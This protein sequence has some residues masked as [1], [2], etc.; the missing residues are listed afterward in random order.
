MLKML[1]SLACAGVVSLPATADIVPA[2]IV[3]GTLTESYSYYGWDYDE[4][5]TVE[6]QLTDYPLGHATA[7]SSWSVTDD[8]LSFS[9][10]YVNWSY[11]TE[12]SNGNNNGYAE[13]DFYS[14]Y[15]IDILAADASL[16]T[17]WGNMEYEVWHAGAMTHTGMTGDLGGLQLASGMWT[18]VVK[19]SMDYAEG[20]S[21]SYSKGEY[22]YWGHDYSGE[23]GIDITAVPAP[24]GIAILALA[25]LAAGRR[26]RR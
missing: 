2:S 6:Y 25:G 11:D 20:G 1:M 10:S 19:G 16:L 13:M 21:Y 8:A 5:W 23:G 26:R 4:E 12:D 15:S 22:Y 17:G 18:I 9:S 7:D 24:G 14:S 3:G